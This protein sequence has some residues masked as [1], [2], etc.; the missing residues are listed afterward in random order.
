VVD[1]PHHCAACGHAWA[2]VASPVELC[3]DCWRTVQ[4]GKALRVSAQA[5]PAI[6]LPD[7]YY[8]LGDPEAYARRLFR[9]DGE[10][11][12]LVGVIFD[13]DA[14][15]QILRALSGGE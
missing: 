2:G 7:H 8:V 5:H 9:R 14:A 13:A 3:G 1:D 6:R 4:E 15:Q 11:I 12:I 10:Q